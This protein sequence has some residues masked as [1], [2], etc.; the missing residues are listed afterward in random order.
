MTGDVNFSSKMA[1][2]IDIS[3]IKDDEEIKKL[4]V[5]KQQKLSAIFNTN[6]KKND[7]AIT[8]D[9][10]SKSMQEIDT[11]HDGKLTDAEMSAAWESL[12]DAKKQGI[13]KTEYI[14]YLKAMA[15]ANAAE[16]QDDSKAG[17]SYVIQ[18]GEDFNDLIIRIMKSNGEK[19]EDCTAGTDKFNEYVNRFKADNAHAFKANAD[20]SVKWLIAGQK[21][22]INTDTTSDEAKKNVKDLNNA[23]KVEEKYKKWAD[24]KGELK[25]F[26]YK[27]DDNGNT[28]EVRGS[29][30]TQFNAAA[31][32]ADA[33]KDLDKTFTAP[34]INEGKL[35]SDNK[36]VIKERLTNGLNVLTDFA[37][38]KDKEYSTET[39][40]ITWN[41]VEYNT[42]EFTYDNKK[43]KVL[44]DKS[45]G[46]PKEVW[47]DADGSGN[48]E[49]SIKADGS[50]AVYTDP[51][52]SK[53]KASFSEKAVDFSKVIELL[54]EFNGEKFEDT[55][56]ADS[57]VATATAATL[58]A[59]A[60]DGVKTIYEAQQQ[61]KKGKVKSL[62][63]RASENDAKK[64]S[65]AIY[66]IADG[67]SGDSSADRILKKV[68]RSVNVDNVVEVWKFSKEGAGVQN[69]DSSLIA[70]I[71]SENISNGIGGGRDKAVQTAKFI[72]QQLV[73]RAKQIGVDQTKISDLEYWINYDYTGWIN[74]E[75][76][77]PGNDATADDDDLG[78]LLEPRIDAF[79][80]EID[81]I[82]NM[83]INDAPTTKKVFSK[84]DAVAYGKTLYAYADK[85]ENDE[86]VRVIKESVVKTVNKDNAAKIWKA[87][88]ENG[89]VQTTD[90]SLIATMTSE[91]ISNDKGGGRDMAV[92][93]SVHIMKQLVAK[94]KELGVDESIIGDVEEWIEYDYTGW[95][96]DTQCLPGNDLTADD[97]DLGDL[98]E[99]Y[100]DNIVEA[101]EEKEAEKTKK[102]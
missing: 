34:E 101:I 36:D 57:T 26:K 83:N 61:G 38:A 79:I 48:Y 21:I 76:C 80:Q 60:S 12:S 31:A 96:N 41:K 39:G 51:S 55:A 32:Y 75:K 91:S 25:S 16:V 37:N 7:Q 100:I 73:D 47:I 69:D 90:A 22:F 86:S 18:L 44:Y 97:D 29:E 85:Y 53:T 3:K 71:T 66:D 28:Y 82:E 35:P 19:A 42:K 20:G 8:I 77:L 94:A 14:S 89:G 63:K 4:S 45:S 5:D 74:D 40:K 46:E 1:K 70:T 98:L 30:E 49:V 52:D 24:G 62:F 2:S 92:Q 23:D 78:D 65:K 50:G 84:D 59:D 81:K 64:I 67:D 102:K 13:Q 58:A 15:K 27:I 99:P 87:C 10:L 93:A 9:E 33:Y 17:N 11:N 43:I 56:P 54:K 6:T 88:R 72:M 95:I 68:R